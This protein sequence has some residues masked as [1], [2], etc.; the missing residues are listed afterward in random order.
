SVLS[1]LMLTDIVGSTR[2]AA[3]L[4]DSRWQALLSRHHA[5]V[6]EDLKR[7]GGREIDTAGGGCF[8]GFDEA[9][10]W[11][12]GGLSVSELVAGMG[13]EFRAGLTFGETEPMAG[14]RGG[15]AVHAAARIV[16]LAGPSEVLV[17]PTVRDLVPGSGLRFEDRGTHELRDVP[18]EWR[19]WA[20]TDIDG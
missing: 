17:S 11:I 18:G 2:I 14:K 1:T 3:E 12:R 6:R 7:L 4:G 13:I 10:R 8:G 5:I 9:S 15:V 19:I 16:A 20:V